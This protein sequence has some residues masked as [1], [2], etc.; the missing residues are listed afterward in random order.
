MKFLSANLDIMIMYVHRNDELEMQ[1]RII[2]C[3]LSQEVLILEAFCYDF[4]LTR[5]LPL[6]T[7]SLR[8]SSTHS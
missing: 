2:L 1:L 3:K 6:T 4:N 5:K 7:S 8:M